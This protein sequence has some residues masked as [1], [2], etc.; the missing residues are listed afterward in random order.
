MVFY[1]AVIGW[2]LLSIWILDVKKRI[3]ILTHKKNE[4]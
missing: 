1:P 3:A 2:I 4:E